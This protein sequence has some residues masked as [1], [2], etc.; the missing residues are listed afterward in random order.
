MSDINQRI[1]SLSPEKRAILEQRL[2]E[3]ATQAQQKKAIPKIDRLGSL[4]LSF[5]QQRMWFLER[6]DPGNFAYNRPAAL[7]LTGRLNISVLEKCLKEI[8]ARHEVL[9][10][11][12]PSINGVPQQ[13][14]LPELNLKLSITE[15]LSESNSE[16]KAKLKH[17]MQQESKLPFDLINGPLVRATLFKLAEADHILLLVFHHIVF[18]GWSMGV[19]RQEL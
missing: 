6:L 12:F 1:A 8:T 13:K 14:I 10:T 16:Q 15:V 19:L 17:L 18:D 9:R 4:P 3:K 2:R 7:Q 5:S 11:I